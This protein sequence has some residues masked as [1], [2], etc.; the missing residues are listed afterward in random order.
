MDAQT[1]CHLS[2][3]ACGW[4]RRKVIGDG[5]LYLGDCLDVMP[6]VG[7]ADAVVTYPPYEICADVIA[8]KSIGMVTLS[9]ELLMQL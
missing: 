7:K 1:P 4:L 6:V 2:I 5:T 8:A 9:N 3:D